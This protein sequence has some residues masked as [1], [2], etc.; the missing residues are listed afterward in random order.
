MLRR[1]HQGSA[2]EGVQSGPVYQQMQEES[3]SG[4]LEEGPGRLL[5]YSQECHG[6]VD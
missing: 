6:G 1:V 2:G 5:S 4:V 3:D